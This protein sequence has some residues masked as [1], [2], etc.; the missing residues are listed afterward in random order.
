M[1]PC[2][3]GVTLG[4]VGVERNGLFE[5]FAGQPDRFRGKFFLVMNAFQYVVEGI[6]I[7]DWL[8]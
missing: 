8:G 6:E 4:A 5:T 1:H 3:P 7:R 2:Q